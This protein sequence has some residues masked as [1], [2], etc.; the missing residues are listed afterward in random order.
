MEISIFLAKLLGLYL[1]IVG[2]VILF[3]N[4]V[5]KQNLKEVVQSAGMIEL[6]GIL[7]LIAGLA[8]A[9]GHPIM[10]LSWRG[11][12]TL[13]GYIAIFQGIF[14]LNFPQQIKQLSLKML[15]KHLWAI[16][17]ILILLGGYLTYSGF[18]H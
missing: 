16:G 3:R 18:I 7:S 10:E 14:R 5:M 4:Q 2:L 6:S 15:E 11:L 17:F 1:L 13:I 8:I 9:I 12:I